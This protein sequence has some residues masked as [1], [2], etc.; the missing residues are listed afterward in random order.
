M[1]TYTAD[2]IRQNA[3]GSSCSGEQSPLERVL[4]D[5]LKRL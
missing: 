2:Y 1:L 4:I 5:A 3:N